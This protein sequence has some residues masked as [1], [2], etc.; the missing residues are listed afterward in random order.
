ML[1]VYLS[2]LLVLALTQLLVRW[3]VA[4]LEKRYARVAAEADA[5]LKASSYRGGNCHRP[6]PL[7]AAR[8]QYDLAEIARKRDRVEGR[9]TAWQGRS[10]RL[11]YFRGRLRGYRG[12]LVPYVVGLLDL[13]GVVVLLNNLGVDLTPLTEMLKF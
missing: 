12:K 5:L 1:P 4:R 13:S 6:D 3:R 9:Y 2:L 10:E 8:Q 7:A 11:A